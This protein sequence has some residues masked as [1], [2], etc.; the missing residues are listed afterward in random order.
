M[1]KRLTAAGKSVDVSW[2]F[3]SSHERVAARF[4]RGTGERIHDRL[5]ADCTDRAGSD[6]QIEHRADDQAAD[7]ADGHVALR[8]AG[9]FRRGRDGIEADV[10]EEDRSR[11]AG[12]AH[13]GDLAEEAI[14]RERREVV[15]LHDRH[16]QRDEQQQ[17][18]NLDGRQDCVD[19]CALARADDQQTGHQQADR[20]G[21]QIDQ[22]A[23]AGTARE[24]VGNVDAERSFQQPDEIVRPAHRHCA[25]CDGVLENQCP[26]HHPGNEL[27]EHH[28]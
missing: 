17:S 2:R 21:W 5:G 7:H 19:G 18:R 26:A 23:E 20:C 8:I 27:A 9:L 4:Q 15:G 28:I 10:G 25:R 1:R 6:Q 22:A 13:A 12:D 14:G 11:G 3:T 16:R 24:R